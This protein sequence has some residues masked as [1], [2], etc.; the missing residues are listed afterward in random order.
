MLFVSVPQRCDLAFFDTEVRRN[1]PV[2]IE[3][4]HMR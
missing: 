1:S 2:D 4:L 3:R